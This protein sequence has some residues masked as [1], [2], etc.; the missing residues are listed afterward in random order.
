M[1]KKYHHFKLHSR[2]DLNF[3]YDKRNKAQ[4]GQWLD[5]RQPQEAKIFQHTFK[6]GEHI[7]LQTKWNQEIVSKTLW[8]YLNH[9]TSETSFAIYPLIL[10]QF[11]VRLLLEIFLSP[12]WKNLL[13][14]SW[15]RKFEISKYI[16]KVL[17]NLNEN[18][19]LRQLYV[20]L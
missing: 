18:S 7:L 4:S 20:S 10:N 15:S 13:R 11:Y 8:K 2:Q 9:V 6:N 5:E 12:F 17:L 14:A 16:G 19:N 1:C 3:F